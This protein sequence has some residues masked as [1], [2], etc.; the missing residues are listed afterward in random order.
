MELLCSAPDIA[1]LNKAQGCMDIFLARDKG[2]WF[3]LWGRK[4]LVTFRI[5]RENTLGVTTV[6]RA[7]ITHNGKPNCQ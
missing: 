3:S 7:A 2:R 4:P 1:T 6:R 5:A